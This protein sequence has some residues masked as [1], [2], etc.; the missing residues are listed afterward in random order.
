ME[1]FG[2]QAQSNLRAFES[3]SDRHALG[4]Q[5]LQVDREWNGNQSEW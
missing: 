3:Q 2:D 5:V 1:W 4:Y